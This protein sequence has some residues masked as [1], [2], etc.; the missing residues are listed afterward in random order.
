MPQVDV[1]IILVSYNTCDYTLK[2]IESIYD[3]TKNINFDIWLVDNNSQ[4][5]TCI[6][7]KN[8]FPEVNIIANE[9]NLGFGKA[10]NL[11]INK[12]SGKYVFLLNTDTLLV[13]NAI[14]IFFDFMENNPQIGACGGN[15]YDKNNNHVHSY[16]NFPTIKSE[17]LKF[18]KNFD[19]GNNEQ[20]EKKEV[21]IIIGADLFI[22]KSVLTEV[23]CFDEDFFLYSE[24]SELQFRIKKAGYKIFIL[25]EANIIHLEGKST[26]KR[27]NTRVHKMKGQVLFFKKCYDKKTLLIYKIFFIIAN[28]YRIIFHPVVILRAFNQIWKI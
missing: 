2:C 3:K 15:L 19:K 25:P 6:S 13:N 18:F 16:G 9:Q 23:G 11:A 4:D 5:D 12:C 20:N 24:E 27:I 14:K 8:Q 26:K 22:K 1:S 21:D 7:V 17:F 10:N 28:S